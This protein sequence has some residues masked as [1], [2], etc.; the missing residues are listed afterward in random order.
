MSLCYR[1][2]TTQ[3]ALQIHFKYFFQF[4]CLTIL[5]YVTIITF[6]D[7]EY[8]SSMQLKSEYKPGNEL[9]IL[10]LNICNNNSQ[11]TYKVL[12]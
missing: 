10:C 2:H 11:H 3:I 8:G 5:L 12:I 9:T 6:I 1:E 4:Q 7:Y